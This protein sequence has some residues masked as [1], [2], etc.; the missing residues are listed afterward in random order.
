MKNESELDRELRRVDRLYSFQ[1]WI[2]VCL[3]VLVLIGFTVAFAGEKE[4][5]QRLAPK[6]KADQEVRLWDATRVD[7][8]SETHAIEVDYAPKWAEAIG[9]SAY[10]AL[11]SKKKP[12]I[13]LLVKDVKKERRYVYRCQTVCAKY[14]IDLWIERVEE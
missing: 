10:Y 11:V 12:G 3:S 8:L 14:D 5:T 6:Y 1:T 9:Q 4:E 13:I 2:I 7:L